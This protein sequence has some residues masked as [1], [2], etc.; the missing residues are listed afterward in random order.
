MNEHDKLATRLAL[1]LTRFNDGERLAVD[2]LAREFNVN[3]RTIQRD[4]KKLSCLPIEKENGFYTLAPYCLGKLTYKDIKQFA[5]FSGIQELYPELSNELI[6]DIL[7]ARVNK[8]MEVRGHRY[9]DLSR[10]VDLFNNIGAAILQ[11]RQVRFVYHEK[12]RSAEPYKLVNTN[13]IWYVVATQEGVVKNFSLSKIESLS[14][15]ETHFIPDEKIE[16]IL[17]CNKGLWYTQNPIDV[18]LAIDA[19]VA[20]YFLR[21]DL[22]PDQQIIERTDEKLIVSARVAYEE[23]I[24]KTVRYWIPHLTIISPVSLQEKLEESLRQYLQRDTTDSW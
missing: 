4:F 10:K 18:T 8:T 13:G 5:A 12:K 9:E 2:E 1:I 16:E 17:H 20:E 22:L 24:L 23:E 3:A 7:N 21:R 6:V 11:N 19:S 14:V 15:T